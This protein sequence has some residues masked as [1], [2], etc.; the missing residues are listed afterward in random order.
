MKVKQTKGNHFTIRFSDNGLG[1]PNEVLD[2]LSQTLGL[3]LIQILADQIDGEFTY[4]NDNGAVCE[5]SFV[6]GNY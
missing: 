6:S 3:E 4:F 1:F 2:D 5:I